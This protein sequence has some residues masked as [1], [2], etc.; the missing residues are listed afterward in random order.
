MHVDLVK[1]SLPEFE[2]G[3]ASPASVHS[4]ATQSSEDSNTLVS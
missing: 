1:R 3:R 2:E 4:V